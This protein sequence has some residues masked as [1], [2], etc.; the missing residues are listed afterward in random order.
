MINANTKKKY[1]NLG[2]IVEQ[3][4]AN[5]KIVEVCPDGNE[6]KLESKVKK[7]KPKELSRV[8]WLGLGLPIICFS[9]CVKRPVK[10][11]HVIV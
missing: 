6:W 5:I 4:R 9:N 10:N 2:I 8:V 1:F 11:K 3:I 7:S